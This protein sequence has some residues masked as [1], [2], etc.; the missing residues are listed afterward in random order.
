VTHDPGCPVE[1]H[2][3]A[4]RHCSDAVNLH[5]SAL[6]FDAMKKWVAVRLSDGRSDGTLYDTK[7]DAV[8][9][10]SSE[11]L[12]AYV[13]IPP[14]GMGVCSAEAFLAVHRKLYTSGFRLADPDAPHGGRQVI[15]R[16]TQKDQA[17]Q[18]AALR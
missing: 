18:T 6:G 10:Q 15:P 11:Q 8:R 12:C 2:S 17:R 7:R 16:L 5:V 3:D 4:A 13:C 1:K 9:H 14:N